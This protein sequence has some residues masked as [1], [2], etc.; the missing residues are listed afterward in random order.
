MCGIVGFIGSEKNTLYIKKMNDAQIH[1]GPDE[2]GYYYCPINKVHLGMS[3]LS[4]I[5]IKSGSQPMANSK[6]DIWIIYNG[7]IFNSPELRIQLEKLGHRFKTSNSDTEV[8]LK[9]YEEYGINMLD[10]LNGMFALTIYDIKKNKL[11]SARDQFGIKPFFYSAINGKYSFSSEIKSLLRLPWISKVL[12][13]NSIF[14][15]FSFQFIPD[16]YSV[17]E[18]IKKLLPGHYLEWDIK[19]RSYKIEKYSS[20]ELNK[21]I[22]LK[23]DELDSFVIQNLATA[24][25]RWTLSDVPIACSLSGG[26]DS[27]AILA[28]MASQSKKTI[29]TFTLGFKDFPEIDERNYANIVSKKYATDHTEIIISSDD[30]LW[31]I[32][33]MLLALDEPYAG[34][35]PSWFVYK[36]MSKS[37]KVGLT[38]TGA[39]ELFGNY[40]KWYPYLQFKEFLKHSIKYLIRKNGGLKEYIFNNDGCLY[41]PLLFSNYYKLKNLFSNDF[42]SNVQANS[43]KLINDEFKKNY[44]K[45]DNITLIDFKYQLPE[46]FLFMTDRFSMAHSLEIRTPFLDKE[47]TE[48][49]LSIRHNHRFSYKNLK[50]LLKNSIKD[51]V[52]GEILNLP[53]KGFI[54]PM[55]KWLKGPLLS[56]LIL[57]SEK[58]FLLK[59][60]IFQIDIRDKFITP[61]INNKTSNSDQVWVWWMFQK[62]W[63]IHNLNTAV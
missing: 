7:E 50:S 21:N 54:L 42:L 30:L 46:E 16:T 40:G 3:R 27:S 52:P 34:G 45:I 2:S 23:K 47:F 60:N 8:I 20:I 43:E 24:V 41:T 4:I 57:F 35:L 49:M 9:M 59:Q 55:E 51:L 10:K 5:D 19:N 62:W 14:H 22:D 39:D 26:I 38:G 32:D 6:N 44:N 17:Y 61:F 29:K 63:S 33:K 58:D 28:I 1:R 53:K 13:K 48:N 25:K 15:Y 12:N 37:V 11:F 56:D 36:E 18:D 31:E